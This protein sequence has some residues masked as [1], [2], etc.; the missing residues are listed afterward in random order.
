M[1]SPLCSNSPYAVLRGPEKENKSPASN[2]EHVDSTKSNQQLSLQILNGDIEFTSGRDTPYNML[3]ENEFQSYCD[4]ENQSRATSRMNSKN[5]YLDLDSPSD[6]C[7]M[8][9]DEADNVESDN[10]ENVN[11]PIDKE[12]LTLK[13]QREQKKQTH[14]DDS[15]NQKLPVEESIL[16][17]ELINSSIDAVNRIESLLEED[18]ETSI[19][20]PEE[21]E[22]KND[23]LKLCDR[24]EG[25]PLPQNLVKCVVSLTTPRDVLST[26]P[27]E[28]PAFVE[29]SLLEDGYACLFVPAL[30]PQLLQGIS[31]VIGNLLY[32]NF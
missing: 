2:T 4:D 31:Y 17:E 11:K 16:H 23:L 15:K 27:L 1:G 12:Q 5:E 29:F 26:T 21:D 22:F 28:P 7:V 19:I 6:E 14:E 10:I 18:Y 24:Y 30:T 9:P 13:I 32:F 3:E 8:S 25:R 20:D